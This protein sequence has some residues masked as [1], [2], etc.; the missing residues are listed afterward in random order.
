MYMSSTVCILSTLGCSASLDPSKRF[1]F[2]IESRGG[3]RFASS[4]SIGTSE[5]TL[6]ESQDF[7]TS[8]ESMSSYLERKLGSATFRSVNQSGKKN[9]VIMVPMHTCV[10]DL[11]HME[12]IQKMHDTLCPHETNTKPK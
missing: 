6:D 2:C 1:S 11:F 4:S 3:S 10:D 12:G 5:E 8:T 7:Y 9:S